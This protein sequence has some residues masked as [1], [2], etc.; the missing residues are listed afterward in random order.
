MVGQLVD[1]M[2][3]W[4][5]GQLSDNGCQ[6]IR[7]TIC[8]I[9]SIHINTAKKLEGCTS[10]EVLNKQKSLIDVLLSQNLI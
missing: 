7:C 3:V 4:L 10:V 8:V 5:F 1:Y 6:V 2:L 9:T